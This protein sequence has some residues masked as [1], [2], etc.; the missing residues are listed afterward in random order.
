MKKFII[1]FL[2][3]ITIALLF[4][5][6]CEKADLPTLNTI[7]VS[8]I[9]GTSAVS[10]GNI[11]SDGGDAIIERGIC[12]S[13]KINP[14][15]T[16]SNTRDGSGT[17]TFSSNIAGLTEGTLYH[18]RAYA[19]NSAGTTYGQQVSFT[20][21][22]AADIPFLI[23]TAVS[24]ITNTSA[25]SGGNVI[26]DGGAAVTARGVCWSTS[27]NPTT[28]LST[29]TIDGTGI[30]KFTSNIT[31]LTADTTFFVRAYAANIIGTA[32]GN[33]VSFTKTSDGQ[34]GTVTDIDGNVYKTITIGTQVWM[35]ENMKTT[36]Y[37]DGTP[38][39]YVS[40]HTQWADLNTE[41]YC[42]YDNNPANSATYG[43][44]YNWYVVD[45]N[46]PK[47]VCPTG[48]HVPTDDEW[49]T[50]ATFLGGE[51]VAG[52]KLKETG[53]T[54]WINSNAGV[55]N[56]S[57]FTALPGGDRYYFGTFHDIGYLG[58]WWSATESNVTHAWWR[59][60]HYDNNNLKRHDSGKND[61]FSLRCIR[62]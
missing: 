42:D 57:G 47:K 59:G 10:G 43:R 22:T 3:D 37:C 21:L 7:I 56:E 12:W 19:T 34:T 31:S 23:T 28:D 52:G 32:Y 9:T 11:T 33:E 5:T 48:W 45:S 50:L 26:S 35:A 39:P 58:Y 24:F 6:G 49:T 61:G 18:V 17:G 13:N 41:A 54:H 1:P 2:L 55:S 44:L 15:I 36:R 51:S 27:T 4:L 29:K 40:D 20:T 14:T 16:D 25:T 62:D 60:L 53:T 8:S 30:G 46:N 38:I